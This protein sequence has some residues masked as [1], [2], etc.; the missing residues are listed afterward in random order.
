MSLRILFAS[1]GS[2]L[3]SNFVCQVFVSWK[4]GQRVSNIYGIL[5][6]DVTSLKT[7]KWHA[8]INYKSLTGGD[9]SEVRFVL[10]KIMLDS[11]VPGQSSHAGLTNVEKD[12]LRSTNGLQ[13]LRVPEPA[14]LNKDNA[15]KVT[16]SRE[17]SSVNGNRLSKKLDYDV[18][19]EKA[20]V[21]T[22]SLLSSLF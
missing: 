14:C 9:V 16:V 5:M 15:K 6:R 19:D 20:M 18:K 8:R 10:G 12:E 7:E 11:M 4:M 21:K 3:C 13:K 22:R 17:G 1:L 2:S